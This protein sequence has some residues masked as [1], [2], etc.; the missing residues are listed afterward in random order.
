[1]SSSALVY[2]LCQ[3]AVNRPHAK[4]QFI[5]KQF[6]DK[7]I[8]SLICAEQFGEIGKPRACDY[9]WESPN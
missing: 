2:L 9:K 5:I 3:K 6:T 1:M 8:I 4:L 7:K